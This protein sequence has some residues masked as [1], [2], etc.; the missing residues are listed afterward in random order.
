MP[1][2]SALQVGG[3]SQSL[4]GVQKPEQ[5]SEP[6]VQERPSPLQGLAHWPVPVSQKPEQQAPG[7]TGQGWPSTVQ[8][9]AEAQ[10]FVGVPVQMPVQHS[11]STPQPWPTAVQG[12]PQVPELHELEQQDASVVQ[13]SPFRMQGSAQRPPAPQ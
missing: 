1:T 12:S 11:A 8:D 5:Q 6:N 13:E 4:P 7:A 2:S 9:G 3:R 10:V